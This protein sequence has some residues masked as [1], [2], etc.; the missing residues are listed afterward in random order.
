M[1]KRS[2][3][4]DD[5]LN[6]YMIKILSNDITN[7]HFYNDRYSIHFLDKDKTNMIRLSI[8]VDGNY[9]DLLSSQ[10]KENNEIKTLAICD[11]LFRSLALV[12]DNNTKDSNNNWIESYDHAI[13]QFIIH[14]SCIS[15]VEKP[16]TAIIAAIVYINTMK[17][18]KASTS[19]SLIST[20][21]NQWTEVGRISSQK[22]IEHYHCLEDQYELRNLVKA[23]GAIAFVANGSILPRAGGD[24]DKMLQSNVIPFQSPNTLEK[25][26]TLKHSGKVKGMLIP[27]GVT[28]ITGGGYNGKSTLLNALKVG[29]YSKIRGDGR[30]F[31]IIDK[32]GTCL[33][34]EDGR[35]ISSVN[36]SSFI[37]NLP[38]ASDLDTTNLCTSNASG[39]TSMA[40]NVIENLEQGTS[41]MLLDEDTCASNFMI[42]DSRMRSLIK[43]EPIIPY[44][45]RVNGLYKS[46]D[47]SSIVV[48]GGCGDWFDVQNQTIM[49]D[50]YECFDVTNR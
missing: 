7:E 38:P 42:R 20:I 8:E 33:R 6:D 34:S 17:I 24:S 39:S 28:V 21:I 11:W 46:L 22:F 47:V 2:R 29:V 48:V 9:F 3:D 31:V 10:L 35:Y 15:I 32:D 44:I 49:M 25:E 50:N 1:T 40:A 45:Y 36:V 26:F 13:D 4:S 37:S 14:R 27:K 43:N 18:T 16:T 19:F 30:E 12:I 5:D 23:V 41:V